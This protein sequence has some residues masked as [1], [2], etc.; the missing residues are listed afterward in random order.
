MMTVM[1]ALGLSAGAAQAQDIAGL[2]EKLRSKD[3]DEIESARSGLL[4]QGS[5]ALAPLREAAGKAEDGAFK[6]RAA[7]VADRLETRQAAAGLAGA[8]GDRW[9]SIRHNAL[10]IGWV[11][12]TAAEKD[13]KIE[14]TDELFLQS[15]K[16]NSMTIKVGVSCAPDEFL[17]PSTLRLDIVG[18]D[19]PVSLEGK[20]KEG[21]LIVTAAGEKKAHPVKA[22]LV[23]DFAMLRLV[24]ILPRTEEY[25]VALLELTKPAVKESA[26]VKFDREETIELN[27]KKVKARRF[28]LSDGEGE[29]RFYWAGAAGELYKVEAGNGIEALLCDEKTAKDLD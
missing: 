28:T 27:G 20:L 4:Q 8:W 14:L 29:D 7:G 17:T 12:A 1:L 9:Y 10:K 5:A 16:D 18:G 15:S 25:S 2:I 24:T 26:A 22:N 21:R 6:K 11:H 19:N 13:G 3:G 23:V